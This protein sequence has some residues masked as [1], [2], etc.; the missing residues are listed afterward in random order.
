MTQNSQSNG[1]AHCPEPTILVV[2]DGEAVRKM[3]CAMLAQNGYHCF[4]AADGPEALGMLRGMGGVNL[5]LTD[6]MMPGMNGAELA[7]AI[8]K[9]YPHIRI[10]FMSGYSDDSLIRTPNGAAGLFLAKPFTA[11]A[12]T[13]TVRMALNKPW[14][15]LPDLCSKT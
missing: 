3:I 10:V 1:T 2:E 11:S 9:D 8:S 13:E 4:E 12:L 15:G 14:D 6:M 5:V 7:K